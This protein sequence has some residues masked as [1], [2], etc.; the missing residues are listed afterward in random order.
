MYRSRPCE[1]GRPAEEVP[2]RGRL[3]LFRCLT[4]SVAHAEQEF[5]G[6]QSTQK[7]AVLVDS[8]FGRNRGLNRCN[9][10]RRL[11]TPHQW[12]MKRQV[13]RLP[14]GFQPSQVVGDRPQNSGLVY[15]DGKAV[16]ARAGDVEEKLHTEAGFDSGPA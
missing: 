7:G 2:N 13:C 9:K 6:L 15:E 14:Y 12:W 3:D 4:A 8:R 1:Q 10:L 5:S 11:Q 16:L